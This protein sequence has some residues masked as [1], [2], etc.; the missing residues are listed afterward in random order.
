MGARFFCF[1]SASLGLGAI[2]CAASGSEDVAG[3]LA[4]DGAAGVA[5]GSA[6]DAGAEGDSGKSTGPVVV[7]SGPPAMVGGEVDAGDGGGTSPGAGCA[8]L[9]DCPYESATNVAGVACLSDGGCAITCNG[10][11]YDV[12]G[13]LSNGCEVPQAC[14]TANSTMLCPVDDHTQANAADAGSFSCDDSASGQ[15]FVGNVPSDDRA[16]LPMVDGFV[17]LTGSAPQ[18][19]H[20]YGSG[21]TFCEDDANFSLAMQSPTKQMSCY[22]LTL[23][24]DK[25]TQTCNTDSSGTCSISN[26][27]GSY[28]DGSDIYV[29]V[30]KLDYTEAD[31]GT[32]SCAAAESMDD[33]AFQVTGHL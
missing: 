19:F 26:G 8:S 15:T 22:T 30:S 23:V 10:E 9:S 20:M 6:E 18:F 32:V 21:G 11:N 27:S 12:D 29:S 28:T 24:T 5:D 3:N 14:P 1:V 16:H 2:A 4:L 25:Q 13:V 33:G 31:G 17:A 7:D